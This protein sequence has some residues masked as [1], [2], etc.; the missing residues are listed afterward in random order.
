M[1]LAADQLMRADDVLAATP[2]RRPNHDLLRTCWPL[3]LWPATIAKIALFT[4]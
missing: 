3:L 2:R 1:M 4:A